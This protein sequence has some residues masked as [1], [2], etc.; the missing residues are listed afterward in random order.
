[1]CIADGA[2][3]VPGVACGAVYGIRVTSSNDVPPKRQ[4]RHAISR[5]LSIET[6]NFSTKC[7]FKVVSRSTGNSHRIVRLYS[8]VVRVSFTFAVNPTECF[9]V[10]GFRL[11]LTVIGVDIF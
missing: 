9:K 1:M 8:I 5:F 11:Q 6:A 4:S 3:A 10:I 2:H 7:V